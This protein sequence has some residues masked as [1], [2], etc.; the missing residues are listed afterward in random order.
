M[1]KNLRR[2]R[3][4]LEKDRA[5]EPKCDFFPRTFVLPSE[6]HLFLE[7]FKRTLGSTWIMKP[8]G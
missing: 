8:V 4:N 6:Y 3:K 5:E 2:H 7:E 1:V